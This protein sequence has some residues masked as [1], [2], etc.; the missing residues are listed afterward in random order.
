MEIAAS[1]AVSSVILN[2]YQIKEYDCW[3]EQLKFYNG[4]KCS[5][6]INCVRRQYEF[7]FIQIVNKDG[8]IILPNEVLNCCELYKCR[9]KLLPG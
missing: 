4:V 7:T 8:R 3:I 1:T 2:V 6:V 5:S 9:I